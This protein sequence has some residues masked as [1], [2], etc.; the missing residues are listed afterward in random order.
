MYFRSQDL[1]PGGGAGGRQTS[2]LPRTSP[3]DTWPLGHSPPG[4]GREGAGRDGT[5]LSARIRRTFPRPLRSSAAAATAAQVSPTPRRGQLG[6]QPR[7]ESVREHLCGRGCL[8][9]RRRRERASVGAWKP[10]APAEVREE[11]SKSVLR[12]RSLPPGFRREFGIDCLTWDSSASAGQAL[13]PS[14]QRDVPGDCS[15]QPAFPSSPFFLPLA[16]QAS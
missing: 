7:V 12:G 15:G 14:H 2:S 11:R 9:R 13:G 1:H 4:R 16:P 5:G 3:P 10:R 6:R 8:Q